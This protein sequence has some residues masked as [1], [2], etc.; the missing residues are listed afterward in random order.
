MIIINAYNW[1]TYNYIEKRPSEEPWMKELKLMVEIMH[2]TKCSLRIV[3]TSV[4]TNGAL[5]I[6]LYQ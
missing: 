1:G 3:C 4:I 2:I 6:Q 5:I